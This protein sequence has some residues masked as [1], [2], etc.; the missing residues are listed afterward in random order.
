MKLKIS[1][2]TYDNLT[3]PVQDDKVYYLKHFRNKSSHAYVT[4]EIV[5]QQNPEEMHEVSVLL[6]S[7]TAIAATQKKQTISSVFL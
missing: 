7:N 3:P 4:N 2:R 1:I 5:W 6:K